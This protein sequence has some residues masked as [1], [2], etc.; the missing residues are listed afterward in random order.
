MMV[1]I[2]NI[3]HNTVI[4]TVAI[5]TQRLAHFIAHGSSDRAHSS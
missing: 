5:A 1:I 3:D 4:N 2:Q